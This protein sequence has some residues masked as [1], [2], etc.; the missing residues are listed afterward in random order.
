[1][2]TSNFKLLATSLLVISNISVCHILEET[3]LMKAARRANI[4]EMNNQIKAGADVNAVAFCDWPH[5]GKPVLRYAI[6]SGNLEAVQI[7]LAAEADPNNFTESP[8]I[9][10]E[11]SKKA[12]M[13]NL[14]LLSHAINSG[15]SI[16]IIKELINNGAH[17]DGSPKIAG[18]WSA[19]MI[20]AFR[21]NKEAVIA[22]LQ[23]G[24]DIWAVNKMDNKTAL[25][26]AKEMKHNEIIKILESYKA[27]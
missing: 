27:Q 1:M 26:Y 17:L 4:Q 6:D 21:G 16:A 15:A 3:A 20:A 10:S 12:N 8:L 13:R 9:Y 23:A 11:H 5:G 22:L 2:I 24:A 14:S 19:L 25:D 18:D 7:L